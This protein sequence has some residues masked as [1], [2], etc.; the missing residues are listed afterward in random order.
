VS[1]QNEG[2]DRTLLSGMTWN[3]AGRWLGQVISWGSTLIVIRFLD[4]SDYGIV[5]M[6]GVLFSLISIMGDGGISGAIVNR[7]ERSVQTLHQLTTI[8]VLLG[9][10]GTC[11]AALLSVP[12]G[13]F[14]DQP[15]LPPVVL[16]VG[17]T[18]AILG[19]R[20]VPLAVLQ[21][22]MAFRT[23]AANDLVR[24][25]I[26]AVTGVVIAWQGG[27]YWALVASY[28]A[29]DAAATLAAWRAAPQ[30]LAKP[31]WERIKGSVVFG[32]HLIVAQFAGWVRGIADT[33]IIGKRLGEG[34]LGSYRVAGDLASMP[35]EKVGGIILQVTG[36][37]FASIRTD[38][39]ALARYFM[40]LTEGLA[41]LTWPLAI[42]L[43]LVADLAVPVLLGE[44]WTAA[45]VPLRIFA[46][47][48]II[49][50]ISPL[51]SMIVLARGYSRLTAKV[52]LITTVLT[53]AGMLFAVRWGVVGV[54]VVWGLAFVIAWV[55]HLVV[56]LQEVELS[57]TRYGER[58]A[59]VALACG[60]E[61]GAVLLFRSWYVPSESAATIQ[62]IASILIGGVTYVLALGAVAH[63]RI[64]QIAATLKATWLRQAPV[65][66]TPSAEL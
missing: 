31:E 47:A 6:G 17:I 40:L 15:R 57:A 42:G 28:L 61:A 27:G 3:A 56:A 49:R 11:V 58:L 64:R 32:S 44:Q 7:G 37:V 2:L 25:V 38:R 1:N 59:P 41:A 20:V 52:S 46:F 50:T 60:I 33:V 55:P 54:A 63:G 21:R 51:A 36:P 30:A 23:L 43:V 5:A 29:G 10:A 14:F 45:I 13:A 62:L 18:Y 9:L 22:D 4:P 35:L 65:T 24:V 53:V 39:V 26:T 34:L 48:A 66:D 19:F 16:V 8:S 12:L